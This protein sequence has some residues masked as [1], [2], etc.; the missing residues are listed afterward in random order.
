M[1]EIKNE[2]NLTNVGNNPHALLIPKD[3]SNQL[4]FQIPVNDIVN[5]NDGSLKCVVDFTVD[6]AGEIYELIRRQKRMDR[7]KEEELGKRQ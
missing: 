2:N 7:F 3:V 5:E 6:V 4:H 1:D